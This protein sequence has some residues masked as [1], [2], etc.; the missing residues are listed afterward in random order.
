VRWL[1]VGLGMFKKYLGKLEAKFC[2]DYAIKTFVKFEACPLPT[3]PKHQINVSLRGG[4]TKQ[5]V[6]FRRML[7]VKFIAIAQLMCI[8]HVI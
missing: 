8:I 2:F 3:N 5:S 1:G 6:S 7:S 4:T